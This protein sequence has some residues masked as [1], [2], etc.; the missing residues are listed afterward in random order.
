[1]KIKDGFAMRNIAG[2]NIVVPVGGKANE[3]N[4]MITLNE[5]GG[6]L[7][8]CFQQDIT[9]EKAVQLLTAE[10]AVDEIRAGADISKFVELLR[11]NDLLDE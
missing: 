3:F 9:E 10:Y 6:F 7:W 8:Q 2:S 1:M 11:K 4:G 5:T